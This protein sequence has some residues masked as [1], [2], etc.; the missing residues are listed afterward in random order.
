MPLSSEDSARAVALHD[1]GYS[2]REVADMLGF[3]KSSV[4]R[5]VARFRETGSYG[6][7]PGSG[8]NRATSALDDR[9]IRVSV[10][11]DR[12][13]SA[14]VIRNELQR[15]RQVA[16]NEI[17]VRRR[18]NE[19]NLRARRPATGPELLR[20]H[21]VNRLL[22]SQEHINWNLQEWRQ[23]LFSDE[24]RFCLRSPDG[25][26]RVWRRQGERFAQCNFSERVSFGGGSIMVWAGISYDARTELVFIDRGTL[27][28]QRYIEEILEEHVVVFAQFIGNEFVFMHDNA[29]PHTARIVAQYLEEV[30]INVMRWPA[31]SPDINP[32]EHVWDM[33]GRRIRKRRGQ[34]FTL[35][36]LRNALE[37]EW[38]NIP[39][40]AIQNLIRGMNRRLV[41]VTR[42]RG[43]NTRY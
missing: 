7:R 23:V 30:G 25:R 32:I 12:H 38:G 27:T 17:T 36:Q 31:R 42:A 39:Q 37:E 2:Y 18:L 11:R 26:E 3:T 9:F 41:A 43:G 13:T 14:V 34:L 6:R 5:A 20:Q 22:F 29:R 19:V 33:L 40:E 8:R 1:V 28:A 35:Q 15:V 4:E 10:L 21:R 16:V 24:S